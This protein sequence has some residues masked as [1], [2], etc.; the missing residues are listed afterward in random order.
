MWARQKR[1]HDRAVLLFFLAMFLLREMSLMLSLGASRVCQLSP[2]P[3]V[4]CVTRG[5]VSC[6]L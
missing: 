5:H 6:V 2:L 4:F 3:V 1:S